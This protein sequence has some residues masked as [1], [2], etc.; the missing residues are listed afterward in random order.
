MLVQAEGRFETVQLA[1][2]RWL[3]SGVRDRRQQ[4]ADDA[5]ALRDSFKR[6]RA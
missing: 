3:A 4:H 1:M 5:Q 6:G 2:V